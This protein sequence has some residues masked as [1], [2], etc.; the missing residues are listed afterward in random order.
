MIL[1]IEQLRACMPASGARAPIFVEALNHAM[2]EFDIDT[3]QRVA[4]FLAQIA[5]ESGSLN[6]VEELASGADYE[7]RRDLGNIYEGDGKKFKGVGLMQVTGRT[8]T[9]ACLKALGRKEFDRDYLLTPMGASRSAAWFWTV[10]KGLNRLAD[11]GRFWSISKLI[12]GG[13]NGLDERIRHYINCRKVL[14][15]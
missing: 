7:G 4:C 11:E 14:G 13:T 10:Y 6:Y 12:N 5:H 8:N 3:P 15:L 9:L 2:L 1:T